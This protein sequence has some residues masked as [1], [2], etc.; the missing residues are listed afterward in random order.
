MVRE[1]ESAHCSGADAEINEVCKQEGWAIGHPVLTR[2]SQGI[3]TC[4]CSCFAL[5][6]PIFISENEIKAIQEIQ[7][8]DYVYAAGLDLKWHQKK[9]V[10]SQGTIGKSRQPLTVYID[11]GDNQ[12]F[13]VTPDSLFLME[14]KKLKRADKLTPEDYLIDQNGNKVK[15]NGVDIGDFYGGFHHIATATEKPS[16]NLEGHL[17]LANGIVCGDYNLQIYYQSQEA[18]NTD[19]FVETNDLTVGTKEYKNKYGTVDKINDDL[20]IPSHKNQI[21]EPPSHAST[22]LADDDASRYKKTGSFRGFTDP[23]SRAWAE[24]LIKQYEAYYP[25]INFLLDWDSEVVNAFAWIDSG[26]R[27]VQLKGGLVRSKELEIEGIAL[28]LAHEIGH[29]Y[30]GD[31]VSSNG[32]SCEGQADFYGARD[33]MRRVWFGEFYINIMEKA[34]EQL[35]EFF[36]VAYTPGEEAGFSCAHPPG[37]CRI[38]TY[39]AAVDLKPKPDCAK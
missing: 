18:L 28:V 12:H 36:K 35:S 6:T 5:N 10:F 16:S 22:F 39:N 3:C 25:D 33:V 21:I 24:Y 17:I 26:K 1:C 9:V 11:Y 38:E 31:P 23:N 34:I 19:N 29:H 20:F 27:Y 32:L 2:D 37:P 7:E 14:N 13:I 30:G 8:G 15:I 4:K